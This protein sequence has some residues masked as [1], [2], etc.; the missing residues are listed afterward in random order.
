[1][2]PAGLFGL[3]CVFL[4]IT[5]KEKRGESMIISPLLVDDIG[6]MCLKICLSGFNFFT[7]RQ[8]KLYLLQIAEHWIIRYLSEHFSHLLTRA[9]AFYQFPLSVEVF[10]THLGSPRLWRLLMFPGTNM[11]T[12]DGIKISDK[13]LGY[14]EPNRLRCFAEVLPH[15]N[16]W[17]SYNWEGKE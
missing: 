14:K 2:L 10:R 6:K 5:C 12:M 1:M 17:M 9:V 15:L 7:D 8:S 13:M 16:S 11:G 4:A 3:V